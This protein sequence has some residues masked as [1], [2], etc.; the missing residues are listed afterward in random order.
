MRPARE[1]QTLVMAAVMPVV[2]VMMMTAPVVMP[3]TM[4][5]V[6]PMPAV[7]T[8]PSVI[9]HLDEAALHH[10]GQPDGRTEVR[11]LRRSGRPHEQSKA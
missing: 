7:V 10:P 3:V 2:P 8:V 6:M 9:A 5:A 1:V 11:G 4:V